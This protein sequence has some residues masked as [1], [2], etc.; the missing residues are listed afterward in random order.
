M[1][2]ARFKQLDSLLQSVL[3]RPAEHRDAFLLEICAGDEALERELRS[4]VHLERE[5]G[6]FLDRP[7]I[8]V[9]AFNLAR[10]ENQA[11]PDGVDSRIG[12]TTSHY[13]ILEKIGAGGMG[14]VYK[15]EDE[16]LHRV[17]AVKF[18]SD[19]LARD[20]DALSR[21]RREA[22]TASALNHP[23]ICTIHDIGE[24][25]GRAF[26][27]MEYLEGASLKDRIVRSWRFATGHGVDTRHRNRGCARCRAR[28]RH[29]SPRHQAR[30]HLHQ[31]SRPR[32]DPGLR[33]GQDAQPARARR[34]CADAD[35]HCDAGRHDPWH[36]RVYGARAGSR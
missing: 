29:H 35:R 11:A 36:R 25:D 31:Q 26:I 24:Q 23:N 18:L 32:E 8:E 5:A 22:R 20:P 1:D 3:E 33:S 12:R 34:R 19:E 13:R 15:A 4:L 10:G 21:F 30:Q 17:V 16:R 27:V 9:V 2:P 7:A 28:R 14:V 6:R